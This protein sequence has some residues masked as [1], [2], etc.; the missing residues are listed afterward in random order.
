MSNAIT[1]Q[2][3]DEFPHILN[4]LGLTGIGVEIGCQRGVFGSHVR[5]H[6]NGELQIEVDPYQVYATDVTDAQHEQY[7]QD[8]VK[9]MRATGK[10]WQL[11]CMP[12]LE[13]AAH[14]SALGADGNHGE[15][16]PML[17]WVYLDG[18]HSYEA[19]RDEIAAFWPLIQSGGVLAFHDWVTDGWHR[20]GDPHNAEPNDIP[21]QCGPGPFYVRKAV[22]EVFKPE[23]LIITSPATDMGWQ[24][25][26]V[27]KP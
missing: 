3:R 12:A 5:K 18:D 15:W 26:M 9:V 20:H 19:V 16:D 1:W 22:L 10:P 23:Q 24:S 11:W 4:D 8:A 14:L 6:W 7:I 2:S 17:D 21:G 13:A 25:A 27:V